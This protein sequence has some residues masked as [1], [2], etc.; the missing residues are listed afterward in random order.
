MPLGRRGSSV[1]REMEVLEE[2]KLQLAEEMEVLV[3]MW[4]GFRK[5]VRE[6]ETAVREL[7]GR[8]F[9]PE[10]GDD[11]EDGSVDAIAGEIDADGLALM[12]PME[13]EAP[14]KAVG[15]RASREVFE[16]IM[17]EAVGEGE[18]WVEGSRKR[19]LSEAFP[20][21]RCY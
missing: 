8:G 1:D 12:H 20:Y 13:W 19:K 10:N 5:I 7:P 14:E 4:Q 21:L 18:V 15:L 6:F 16:K 2:A 17:S 11:D 3:E 9:A